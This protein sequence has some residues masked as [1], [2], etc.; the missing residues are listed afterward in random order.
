MVPHERDEVN[1]QISEWLEN[2][3]VQRSESDYASSITKKDGSKRLCV[4][5]RLLNFKKIIKDRYPLP[6]IEDQLDRLQGAKIF[7]TLEKRIFP[8]DE[9]NQKYTAFIVPDGHFEFLRVP[10][11]LCNSPAVFQ[12]YVNATF[13]HLI[14]DGVVLTYMDDLVVPSKDYESGLKNVKRILTSENGL[15]IN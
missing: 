5:Y 1:A 9:S 2:D 4:D 10:F 7:S 14:R 11:G 3:I 8:I 13:K 6:L 15:I 12:K